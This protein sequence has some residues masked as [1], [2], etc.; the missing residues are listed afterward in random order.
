MIVH[1]CARIYIVYTKVMSLGA[2]DFVL[3]RWPYMD[4]SDNIV[5]IIY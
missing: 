5:I 2:C 1:A 4:I 3:I